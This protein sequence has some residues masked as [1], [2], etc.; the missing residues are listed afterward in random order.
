[1]RSTVAEM[2]AKAGVPGFTDAATT[3]QEVSEAKSSV[4]AEKGEALEEISGLIANIHA[5][6]EKATQWGD[7]RRATRP[8]CSGRARAWAKGSS[9]ERAQ[10]R[11]ALT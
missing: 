11:R 8:S 9:C 4:D 2:E 5:Q 7:S 3:L 10:R 1:M 6:R